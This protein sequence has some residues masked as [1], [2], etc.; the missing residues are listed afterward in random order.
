MVSGKHRET[1]HVIVHVTDRFDW[2]IL[3]GR[4]QLRGGRIYCEGVSPVP[5][6]LLDAAIAVWEFGVFLW[7]CHVHHLLFVRRR[8]FFGIKITAREEHEFRLRG[9]PEDDT[10]LKVSSC[11]SSDI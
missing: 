4:D 1:F 7:P 8:T 6:K 3:A 2:C 10:I 9:C 5:G 11:T